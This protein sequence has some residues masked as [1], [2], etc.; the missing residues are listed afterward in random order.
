MST[1]D[2]NRISENKSVLNSISGVVG[3]HS[4][5]F[6]F[7][8][9]AGF[10]LIAILA[11]LFLASISIY[12]LCSSYV[13]YAGEHEIKVV[14]S[15]GV[16]SVVPKDRI[17]RMFKGG[18]VAG[19]YTI[20]WEGDKTGNRSASFVPRRDGVLGRHKFYVSFEA[21]FLKN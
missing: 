7:L 4:I 3:I 15:F 17:V 13:V 10:Q 14:S 12:G 20:V 1:I 19:S 8:V 18:G 11:S 5:L 6:V 9:V 16:E 2:M 21:E